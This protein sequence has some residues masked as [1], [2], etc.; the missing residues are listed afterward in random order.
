MS[1]R[2]L[3]KSWAKRTVGSGRSKQSRAKILDGYGS[4]RESF[5]AL[6]RDGREEFPLRIWEPAAG[7]HHMVRAME[8]HGHRVYTSDVYRWSKRT[9]TII[10]FFAAKRVPKRHRCIVTNPPFYLAQQFAQHAMTL[11]PPGGR[12]YLLLRV[13]WLEGVKRKRELFDGCPPK[14]VYVFSY[15]LPMM[16]A[17]DHAGKKMKGGMMAMAWF[18]F[19][20]NF[21]GEPTIRWL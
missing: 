2:A 18:V 5:D 14:Y 3:N 16:H 1:K 10:D 7:R 4:P 13:Q 12:L 21:K 6:V 20:K 17:F 19:V 15:R 11:L 9:R 8:R